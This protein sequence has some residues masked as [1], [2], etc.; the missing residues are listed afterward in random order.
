LTGKER[1]AITP[2][3]LYI[4]PGKAENLE[5]ILA[6]VD[7]QNSEVITPNRNHPAGSPTGRKN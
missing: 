5:K 4:M 7:A 3:F 2:I 6:K 1:A